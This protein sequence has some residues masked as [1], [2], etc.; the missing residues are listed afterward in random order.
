MEGKYALKDIIFDGMYTINRSIS[1]ACFQDAL[2]NVQ[3]VLLNKKTIN[4][5]RFLVISNTTL[6]KSMIFF[7]SNRL[8]KVYNV[9]MCTL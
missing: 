2:E 5:I 4:C 6:E 3:S 7:C 1:P 8:K 9:Y